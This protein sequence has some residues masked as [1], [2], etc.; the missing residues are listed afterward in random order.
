[1]FG[2][3]S[4]LKGTDGF[5]GSW[6][7]LLDG[8]IH[9]GDANFDRTFYRMIML[10]QRKW[11]RALAYSKTIAMGVM[12]KD[13]LGGGLQEDGRF[14]KELAKEDLDKLAQGEEAARRIIEHAGGRNLFKSPISASHVGG[15]IKIKEHVDEKLETEYRNLHVCDGSVLPG[16]VNTPTLTLICLG[17]YLANQLAPAA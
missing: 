4:G 14:H 5:G 13:G 6:G 11:F 15:T 1:M 9:V 8:G 16:T 2:A 3:I 12:V 7:L 17:K 10:G